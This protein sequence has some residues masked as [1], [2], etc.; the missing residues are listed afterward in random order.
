[1]LVLAAVPVAWGTCPEWVPGQRAGVGAAK[2]S[3]CPCCA[4]KE[5]TS[6]RS[7][8]NRQRHCE[9]CP[10]LDVRQT[11]SPAP[12]AVTLP[13]PDSVGSPVAATLA[14]ALVPAP[15]TRPATGDP[16]GGSPPQPRTAVLLI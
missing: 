4:R 6:N 2:G 16:S 14:L 5:T 15:R 12:A 8:S 9:W 1:M 7:T 3:C 11:A 10:V 13:A